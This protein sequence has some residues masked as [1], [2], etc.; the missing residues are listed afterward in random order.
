MIMNELLIIMFWL[1][2]NAIIGV[3]LF[4]GILKKRCFSYQTGLMISQNYDTSYNGILCGYASCP[5]SDLICGKMMDNPNFNIT[6]F[7]TFLWS[8]LMMFQGITLENWSVNMYYIA[9]TMSY[10]TIFF[11]ISLAFVG[12]YI[13]MNIF[14]SIIIKAY[15]EVENKIGTKIKKV[16]V[17][18]ISINEMKILKIYDQENY[19]K[20]SQILNF[21]NDGK[22]NDKDKE[23]KQNE[24]HKYHDK[25][26]RNEE[27][28]YHDKDKENKQ[29]EEHQMKVYTH[30]NINTTALFTSCKI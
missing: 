5:T 24:E 6:N 10:Y 1:M 9:R 12:S 4:S 17:D 2:I 30:I 3:Q 25:E 18:Q 7:D 21:Q 8:L 15:K 29:N 26:Q 20:I 11:F 23:N 28:K 22:D 16:E 13:L 19:R 27:Q 14:V